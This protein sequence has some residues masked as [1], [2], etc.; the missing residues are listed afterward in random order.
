MT[1]IAQSC[2]V[3]R[4]PIYKAKNPANKP[5]L[6]PLTKAEA[7][8]VQALCWPDV[9][10]EDMHLEV[11]AHPFNLRGR[12]Y[13]RD[14]LRDE[15]KAIVVP[16]GA[17]M[18]L[19]TIFIL[20]SAH[21][22]TVRGR[23]VL[24]LLPLK[25]GSV[26]FVQG[27][28]D[29]ILDSNVELGSYFKRG[30]DN[31]NQKMTA[32]GV[33]WYIRGTNIASELREAPADV[34]VLDERDVANEDNLDDAFARLD[35]S[36]YARTYELST[37]TVDGHGVYGEDGWKATD[38]MRWWVACI[39]CQSYQ[40]IEWEANVMPYL[41]D[42]LADCEDACR[43][44]HCKKPWTQYD[45]AN[46]N[47]SGKWV[48]DAP[49][50][51]VRGYHISQFNSPTKDLIDPRTG[52]LKNWFKGQLDARK[53]KAFYNLALGLPY[54]APGDK[55]T[56]ELLD[57]CRGDYE[58]GGMYT[59]QLCIGVDVGHDVLYVTMWVVD[60]KKRRLWRA[61]TV[62]ADGTR[63]KWQ[64]LEEDYLQ[65]LSNWICVID[66]HPDKE[67]VEALSKKYSGRLWMGFEKD[68]PEQEAT[69]KFQEVKWGEPA[70]VNIDRT[71][72]FDSYIKMFLDGNAS[73]PREARDIGQYM[74]G[75]PYNGFY[76]HHLQMTRVEQADASERII[77]RW[78]N[79][80]VR[81]DSSTQ[82]ATAKAGNRPDHFHHS[83]M[84]AF[85][86]SM[87]DAPLIV[88]ANVGEMFEAAGGLISGRAAA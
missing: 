35:G 29:P 61:E 78:V 88:P 46:M 81:L 36:N 16:K 33:K 69:A 50:A 60:G 26:Q 58:Q 86:A 79:G 2:Q 5:F 37:P 64:V 48:P 20:K 32:K 47:A 3:Y 71:M 7:R 25:T 12:E 30:V 53:L 42:E 28:I 73:L 11:D 14:I 63:T 85:V 74:P 40:V 34:L 54:A 68:R 62:T 83:S 59:G 6:P 70:K 18:G 67:E 10:G 21:A 9:W 49:G 52:I 82:K 8:A 27:R 43:C 65:S 41:G 23:S 76:H 17:Q 31:R 51:D 75:K 72:A 87:Q 39:H 4:L 44:Q 56:V 66:A 15:S 80:K 84:F 19:T 55:F 57:K 38:Q 1:V 77:A 24:Y 22:I 13:E 45:R